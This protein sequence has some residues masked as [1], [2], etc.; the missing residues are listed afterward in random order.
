ME[1]P[2]PDVASRRQIWER[3]LP[4]A[5]HSSLTPEDLDEL[6]ARF[7]LTGGSIRNIALDACYRAL[8]EMSQR[9]SLRQVIASTAREYQK[10]GKPVTGGEFGQRFFSWAM[11]DVVSP[12][13]ADVAR[14]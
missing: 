5:A 9:I 1:F 10:F 6:A 7:E 11:E 12:R 4:G 2:A 8:S 14:A 3:L 13:P